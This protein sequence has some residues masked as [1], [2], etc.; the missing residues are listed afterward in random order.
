MALIAVIGGSAAFAAL[1]TRHVEGRHTLVSL[2]A[3][4]GEKLNQQSFLPPDEQH[5]QG[6]ASNLPAP[7]DMDDLGQIPKSGL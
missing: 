6:G 5:L 7:G 3:G 2:D 1:A 4:S